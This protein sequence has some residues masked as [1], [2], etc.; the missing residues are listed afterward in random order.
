MYCNCSCL[1]LFFSLWARRRAGHKSYINNSNIYTFKFINNLKLWRTN[2]LNTSEPGSKFIYDKW[3]V[4][5]PQH[6]TTILN[7]LAINSIESD[8]KKTVIQCQAHRT[9]FFFASFAMIL[10]FSGH[11]PKKPSVIG[12]PI[13]ESKKVQFSLLQQ[14]LRMA[15][16]HF[17]W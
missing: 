5:A 2:I 15:S 7:L 14:T 13:F 6:K 9:P 8:Y 17:H 16:K 4:K 12:E 3:V 1:M 10:L 11:L